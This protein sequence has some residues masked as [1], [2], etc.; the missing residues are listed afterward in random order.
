VAGNLTRPPW[1]AARTE[2]RPR[3]SGDETIDVCVIGAGIAGLCVAYELA[4]SGRSV[5]VID[6]GTL[7]S[8]ETGRSSAHLS[9]VIDDRFHRVEQVHGIEA[10]RLSY[11]SHSAAIRWIAA[12]VELESIACEFDRVD[13]YLFLPPGEN[14]EL[15]RHELAAAHRAGFGDAELVDRIPLKAFEFGPAIRFPSQAQFDPLAFL[16]GLAAAAERRGVQIFSETHVSKVARNGVLTVVCDGGAS[17]HAAVVVVATNSPINDLVT[18]HT[19][20]HAYRTYAIGIPVAP[21]EVERALYWDTSDTPGDPHAPYH[22]VRLQNGAPGR[23]AEYDLLIVGGEDHK[24]GQADNA[25]ERWTRLENWARLR[26]PVTAKP[27]HRWSGQVMEPVDYLAFIGPN[28][29]GPAGI[30]VVTGDSGMGLTHGAIAGMLINDLVVGRANAWARLYDPS[31]QTLAMAL[32]FAS[33][34][35]NS[36]AQYADWLAA[37]DVDSPARIPPG[38]GARVRSGLALLACYR[39]KQGKLHVRSAACPHLGGV[40][41]WN[42]AE[43]TW[44]CPCHGSRFDALGE[45]INGPASNAL[46]PAELEDE[47][48]ASVVKKSA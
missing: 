9:N 39:D 19:K 12:T 22:Y 32:S 16:L 23:H 29:G 3:L 10:S 41:K 15:L 2:S 38:S 1:T 42:S 36:A 6:D 4:G 47:S 48:R 46:A 27:T 44:D 31:R 13:G 17:V 21:G 5:I 7:G 35:L 25:D 33:E 24:T 30:Y 26:F 45:V 34:N 11:Q 28:P 43:H 8:G 14:V 20:Q 18:L 37:G 40:V